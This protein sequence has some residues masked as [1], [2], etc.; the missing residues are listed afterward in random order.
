MENDDHPVGNKENNLCEALSRA[1]V[2]SR[3]VAT[4]LVRGCGPVGSAV[5]ALGSAESPTQAHPGMG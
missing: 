3:G 1:S 4:P 5:Q 2:T